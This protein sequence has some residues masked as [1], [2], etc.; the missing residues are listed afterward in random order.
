MFDVA[1]DLETK[2]AQQQ[3]ASSALCLQ[4]ISS[5]EMSNNDGGQ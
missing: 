3:I 5:S 4:Q 2:N 1:A